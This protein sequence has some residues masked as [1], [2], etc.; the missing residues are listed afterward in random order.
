MSTLN[1]HSGPPE[2]NDGRLL[3]S[4]PSL[5]NMDGPLR[6]SG[7]GGHT[8]SSSSGATGL[9]CVTYEEG[10]QIRFGLVP[11]CF[12]LVDPPR[13]SVLLISEQIWWLMLR[14]RRGWV[15]L[16]HPAVRKRLSVR[17]DISQQSLII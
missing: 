9:T 13:W 15:V 1:V 6:R 12:C 17:R 2:N 11:A 5:L 14:L 7:G 8:F 3:T 10:G 16:L 4:G